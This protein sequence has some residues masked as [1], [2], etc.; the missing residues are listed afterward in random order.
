MALD[1]GAI[2]GIKLEAQRLGIEWQVL[3]AVA[4]IESAG[5]PLWDGLCPI[6]IE[7][8]YFDKRLSGD[9]R[10]LARKSKLAHP[11]A[12]EIKN[13]AKMAD[14]YK[15]LAEMMK[16]NPE[17]A[18]ESCSWGLGQVMGSHWRRL[19]YDSAR[20]LADEAQH[21]VAGQIRLMGRYIESAGLIGALRIKDWAQF[22]AGYNGQN[23]KKN[24]Y[25]VKLSKAYA[26]FV[27]KSEDGIQNGDARQDIVE[28]GN[29][30]AK[31]RA[32]QKRL[33]ELGYYLGA[34][35]GMFGG[36]TETAVMD[37]QRD[38]KILVDGR[39]GPITLG[40]LEDWTARS[41]SAARAAG[42]VEVVYKNQ[43]ATRNRR[44]TANL[45]TLLANAVFDVF[46]GG[47][48]AQIYSGGQARRGTPGRRT[49]SI[50]HDDYGLGGRALD[51]WIVKPDGKRITGIDLARLGQYWLA[52][53]F[54]GC[55]VE[56][57]E[58]GIHLDEWTTP[59]PGGGM[60]WMYPYASRQPWGNRALQ[61]LIDG[62]RG[63]KPQ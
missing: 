27:K 1:D 47:V 45:E 32:L 11:K 53:K 29:T 51:A 43:Q 19:G 60:Y 24:N 18:L 17:A 20:A 6:R 15:K 40:K 5:K 7:G 9:A 48:Q 12:G 26:G 16:I 36:G 42:S 39:A 25:D 34:I 55:G 35:D 4:M 50:R 30:G 33:S 49:G 58:G 61:M 28:R 31:V 3:A 38:A 52:S 13:P 54:G 2:Q 41:R 62:S 63:V 44:C 21:S 46:G 10:D 14:R 57:A 8:H 37:F 22:A 23:F 59:P 56:M